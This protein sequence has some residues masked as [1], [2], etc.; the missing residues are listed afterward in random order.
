MGQT[1]DADRDLTGE[2]VGGRYVLLARISSSPRSSVYQ[3]QDTKL[4]RRVAVRFPG[5][6]ALAAAGFAERFQRVVRSVSDLQHD[7]LVGVVDFGE[8][9]ELPYAVVHHVGGESLAQRLGARQAPQSPAEVVAWIHPVAAAL[10]YVHEKGEA[11]GAVGPRTV[12]LDKPP[13]TRAYLADFTVRR[14]LSDQRP[15]PKDDQRGLAAAALAALTGKAPLAPGQTAPSLSGVVPD[16]AAKALARA[17][18]PDR[19]KRFESAGAFAAAF[20]SGLAAT[21]ATPKGGAPKGGAKA[22]A[23]GAPMATVS[24]S[25]T[26]GFGRPR[27]AA[28][29]APAPAPAGDGDPHATRGIVMRGRKK[30][31]MPMVLLLVVLVVGAIAFVAVQNGGSGNQQKKVDDNVAPTLKVVQPVD[32]FRTNAPDATVAGTCDDPKAILTVD[33]ATVPIQPDGTFRTVT[34]IPKEGEQT[35]RVKATDQAGNATLQTVSV[36]RDSK[37]P[38][39]TMLGP[40]AKT[41]MTPTTAPTITVEGQ[42]GEPDAEVEVAGQ[43]VTVDPDGKF[44]AEVEIPDDGANT[45]TIV[46]RDDLG[47]ESKQQVVAHRRLVICCDTLAITSPLDGTATRESSIE[48]TGLMEDPRASVKVNG[49]AVTVGRDGVFRGTVPLEGEGEHEIVVEASDPKGHHGTARVRITR[50]L[51]PPVLQITEP[52]FWV[53]N[54]DRVLGTSSGPLNLSGTVADGTRCSLYVNGLLGSVTGKTWNATINLS[55]G[56]QLVNIWAVD[57]AGNRSDP[58][59]FKVTI[60]RATISGLTYKGENEKGYQEFTLDKD[61]TVV[62]VLVPEGGYVRGGMIGDPDVQPD[63]MPQQRIIIGAF[64]VAKGETTWS[65]YL[66]FC[67]DS[68]HALP[69]GVEEKGLL[70]DHP[71]NQVTFDDAMAYC[72]WAGL[73]LPTESEWERAV[74][75]RSED[76]IWPWGSKWDPKAANM[77][78][79]RGNTTSVSAYPATGD[80]LLLDAAGNVSEWCADWYAADAYSEMPVKDPQ[81]PKSGTKRV[82]RGGSWRDKSERGRCSDREGEDPSAR[83]NWIGFRVAASV[84]AK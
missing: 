56:E 32:G 5:R 82:V 15:D 66:R 3:A 12:L 7:G 47:N 58:L 46:A 81:G 23:K 11:H 74:R 18:D 84:G 50:D 9:G 27:P 4:M 37:P 41:L 1:F 59:V 67:K 35:I 71:V 14:A 34:R 76:T 29:E 51:T 43:K 19:A 40:D 70:L 8:H 60:P 55:V 31:S 80:L 68:G 65:Q 78:G 38:T 42:V 62:L 21:S 17:L 13:S 72:K 36:V 45:I 49:Q 69:P 16:A 52:K 57:A 77:A 22:A 79:I 48:V 39:L 73:R 26:L 25:D 53:R 75:F 33:D 64:L 30:S 44:K 24:D 20:S 6:E 10:D 54:A 61:P 83:S 28:A 63:E 2:E